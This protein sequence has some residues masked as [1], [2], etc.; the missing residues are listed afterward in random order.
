MGLERRVESTYDRFTG[1]SLGLDQQIFPASL[2]SLRALDRVRIVDQFPIFL[3][4]PRDRRQLSTRQVRHEL[5]HPPLH[6]THRAQSERLERERLERVVVDIAAE[7]IEGDEL[8]FVVFGGVRR[9]GDFLLFSFLELLGR[10]VE[11]LRQA[12]TQHC[13]Q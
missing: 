2:Q 6:F 5:Q 7:R 10:G 12:Q 4:L 9:R 13:R 11:S 8:D 1:T 3:R